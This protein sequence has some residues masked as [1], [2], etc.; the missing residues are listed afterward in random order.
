MAA[1]RDLRIRLTRAQRE[2]LETHARL[3][4]HATLAGYV[5]SRLFDPR[6]YGDPVNAKLDRIL[7]CVSAK[8]SAE[9]HKRRVPGGK[10]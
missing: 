6:E 10:A 2:L 7:A 3:A 8:T 9:L 5:R 1:T 4:G